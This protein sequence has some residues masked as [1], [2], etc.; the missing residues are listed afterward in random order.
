MAG[1]DSALATPFSDGTVS[2]AMKT[3]FPGSTADTVLQKQFTKQVSFTSDFKDFSQ[4]AVKSKQIVQKA[5]ASGLKTAKVR[6]S[7]SSITTIKEEP[8]KVR[9]LSASTLKPAPKGKGKK[10]SSVQKVRP[11]A[12]A[13]R[14]AKIEQIEA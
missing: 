12:W 1:L 14:H 3:N 9:V 5:V 13:E 2:T 7:M 10:A 6:N 4:A 11:Q 8:E